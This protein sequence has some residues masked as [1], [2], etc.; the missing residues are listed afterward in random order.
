VG[1]FRIKFELGL[2]VV[3]KL[4]RFNWQMINKFYFR[5]MVNEYG[6]NLGKDS[7]ITTTSDGN[8]KII[9]H[10][11]TFCRKLIKYEKNKVK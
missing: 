5:Q 9:L 8:P 3:A 4:N 1:D 10:I 11:N 2:K 7:F 6:M